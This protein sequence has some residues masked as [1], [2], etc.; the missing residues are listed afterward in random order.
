MIGT[1]RQG[2]VTLGN[3]VLVARRQDEILA[4]FALVHAR[5]PDVFQGRLPAIIDGADNRAF[6]GRRDLQHDR[7]DI[8]RVDERHEVD[9]VGVGRQGLVLPVERTGPVDDLVTTWRRP[10]RRGPSPGTCRS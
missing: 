6:I 1:R 7:P 5:R 8:F 3:L 10:W 9:R 2:D 4:A